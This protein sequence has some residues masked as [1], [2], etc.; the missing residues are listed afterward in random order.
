MDDATTGKASSLRQRAGDLKAELTALE[1]EPYGVRV[2]KAPGM[3]GRGLHLLFD[4]IESTAA[5]EGEVIEGKAESL[6]GQSD[7]G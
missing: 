3:I 7:N 1:K 5:A 4:Y 2:M 6:T